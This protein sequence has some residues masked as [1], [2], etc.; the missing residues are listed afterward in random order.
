MIVALIDISISTGIDLNPYGVIQCGSPLAFIPC[1]CS[2]DGSDCGCGVAVKACDILC[3]EQVCI[4]EE[5]DLK[6]ACI[7]MSEI[8]YVSRYGLLISIQH[9]IIH[10]NVYG[11]VDVK[12]HIYAVICTPKLRP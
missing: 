10:G 3:A 5:H 11:K 6:V 12:I 4:I 1:V 9:R 2:P 8:C 7:P